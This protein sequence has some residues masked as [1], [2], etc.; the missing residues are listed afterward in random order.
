V[1][2]EILEALLD[3]VDGENVVVEDDRVDGAL[4]A[5]RL[6]PAAV[7]EVPGAL[8]REGDGAAEEELRDAVTCADEVLAQVLASAGEVAS[9]FIFLGQR[10]DL[11]EEAGA[12]EVSEL[13]GVAAV[14]LDLLAGLAGDEGGGDEHAARV[15]PRDDLPLQRVAAGACLVAVANVAGGQIGDLLQHLAD[16]LWLVGNPPLDR[17]VLPGKKDRDVDPALVDVETD[18][19]GTLHGRL[20]SYAALATRSP[21]RGLRRLQ[22]VGVACCNDDF[23]IGAGTVLLPS[24]L[25]SA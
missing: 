4:E 5:K 10:L 15:T 9:G 20:L 8:A 17:G 1:D 2:E 24:L 11:G 18:E 12:E 19:S 25:L 23:T 22:A 16:G 6:E 14:G 13:L 21:T 7:S 3:L